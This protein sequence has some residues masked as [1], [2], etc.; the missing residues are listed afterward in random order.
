MYFAVWLLPLETSEFSG[1]KVGAPDG[2][3]L[4]EWVGVALAVSVGVVLGVELG[5]EVGVAVGEFI[6]FSVGEEVGVGLGASVDSEGVEDG[7]VEMISAKVF[8][9][10]S[11]SFSCSTTTGMGS[12]IIPLRR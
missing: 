11:G 9:S 5:E 3:S 6:D 8:S 7:E 10:R 12:P 2:D 4:G 1:D